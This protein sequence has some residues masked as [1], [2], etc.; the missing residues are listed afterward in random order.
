[1]CGEAIKVVVH[2]KTTP[3]TYSE[4]KEFS[5]SGIENQNKEPNLEA[6]KFCNTN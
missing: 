3:V 2:P 6:L 5:L 1:L 4:I